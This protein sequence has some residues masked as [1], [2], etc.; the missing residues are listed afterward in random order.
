VI[1]S[2]D[3]RIDDEHELATER[4]GAF[5]ALAI[6][7]LALFVQ[8]CT[9][10][11]LQVQAALANDIAKVANTIQPFLMRTY[12]AQGDRIIEFAVLEVH[13]HPE[14]HDA[15]VAKAAV[16]IDALEAKWR[17]TFVAWEAFAAAHN[18]WATAIDAHNADLAAKLAPRMLD[19]Y[20]KVQSVAVPDLPKEMLEV[21]GLVCP[22]TK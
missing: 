19:A 17:P 7:I 5:V 12:E 10:R 6:I 14:Q 20:C 9:P 13:Q 8:A 2:T 3:M 15:I 16:D 1:D 4:L 21:G 18:A 11:A 22:S